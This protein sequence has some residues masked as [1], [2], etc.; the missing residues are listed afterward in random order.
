VVVGS[1]CPDPTAEAGVASGPT[2]NT[3]LTASRRVVSTPVVLSAGDEVAGATSETCA[4]SVVGAGA[5]S[6]DESVK[7]VSAASARA[8]GLSSS[9]N[10]T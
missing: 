3:A 5:V 2:F 1:G 8:V 7:Y 6:V 10:A 9:Q 4:G